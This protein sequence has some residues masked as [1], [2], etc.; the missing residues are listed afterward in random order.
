MK[1]TNFSGDLFFKLLYLYLTYLNK[2]TVTNMHL[3]YSEQTCPLCNNSPLIFFPLI[4]NVPIE[5]FLHV[6]ECCGAAL[7]QTGNY[8]S[9]SAATVSLTQRLI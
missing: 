2:W 9:V 3:S 5:I 7:G 8:L 4:I 1:S 6:E